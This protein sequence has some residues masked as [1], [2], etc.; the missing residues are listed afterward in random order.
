MRMPL[1]WL[2]VPGNVSG[3]FAAGRVAQKSPRKDPCLVMFWKGGFHDTSRLLC[4]LDYSFRLPT[5][6]NYVRL[7]L[8]SFEFHEL[9]S[10]GS[11]FALLAV[12]VGNLS[13]LLLVFL[14]LGKSIGYKVFKRTLSLLEVI[15][16]IAYYFWAS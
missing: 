3:V 14:P 10:L 2:L 13:V 4:S 15:F 9:L 8:V 1:L 16:H 12:T 7:P 11:A 5:G 6:V